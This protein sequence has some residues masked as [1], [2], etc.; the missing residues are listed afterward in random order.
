MGKF[1]RKIVSKI[2]KYTVKSKYDYFSKNLPYLEKIQSEILNTIIEKSQHSTYL[3][4]FS[5][6]G[7]TN[8]SEFRN[9]VPISEYKDYAPYIEKILEGEQN[10]ITGS[11]IERLGMTSGTITAHKYIPF[12]KD[13]FGEFSQ[14]IGTWIYGLLA[15][16]NLDNGNSYYFSITPSGFP[17]EKRKSLTIGFDEDN[18]YFGKLESF[19]SSQML[20]LP[21]SVSKIKEL[22]EVL[23]ETSFYLLNSEDLALVSIWNPSL[24]SILLARISQNR[25]TYIRRIYDSGNRRRASYLEKVLNKE[26]ESSV[27]EKIWPQLKVISL[28]TSSFAKPAFD[29]LAAYFPNVYFESKGV[30]ATEC[31]ITLP[32][33]LVGSRSP[34]H[35][36]S[37]TSHFYEF[38][39]RSGNV[40]LPSELKENEVYEAIVTTGGGFYR[41]AM[42]DLFLLDGWI[43]SVPI[44][45]F[46]GRNEIVSDLRGEKLHETFL[47]DELSQ[48]FSSH[49][50][51]LYGCFV[52]G[53]IGK[54]YAYYTLHL[55]ERPSNKDM[56]IIE[57]EIDNALK[58][59][60]HYQYARGL[61]QLLPLKIEYQDSTV[62][63]SIGRYATQKLSFLRK[64]IIHSQ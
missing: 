62:Q 37:Y 11:K 6:H 55:L 17:N 34:I 24:F 50:L 52:Q 15:N 30:V 26:S 57:F 2:W 61:G 39:D 64:P 23:E 20:I 8:M 54:K 28:W 5:L 14:A 47:M 29:S 4:R 33:Y 35:T 63:P 53:H 42:G 58:K 36:L 3:K 48:V 51:S 60:P 44:L 16:F 9:K 22:D 19:F 27:W 18:D 7:S 46:I 21:K 56:V 38:R 10:V 40:L 41:Y 12:T 1:S 25:E 43:A 32:F 49:G 45:K 59:N 31:F 13:L